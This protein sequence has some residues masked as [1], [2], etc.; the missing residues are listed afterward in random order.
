M[1]HIGTKYYKYPLTIEIEIISKPAL[2]FPAVT[3]CNENPVRKSYVGR[4]WFYQDLMLLDD[5]VKY[6]LRSKA[7]TALGQAEG[8]D[9]PKDGEG[10]FI[11]FN[12]HKNESITMPNC[13]LDRRKI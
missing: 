12:K 3:V 6:S 10:K 9:C 13:S 11:S 7:Q 2:E 1:Y 8:I 5:H 4:L